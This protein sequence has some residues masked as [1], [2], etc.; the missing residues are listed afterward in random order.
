MT[1]TLLEATPEDVRAAINR[2]P[3]AVV[4]VT[5][6]SDEGHIALAVSTFV[7]ASF[8]PPLVLVCIPRSAAG[9]ATFQSAVAFGVS[10]LMPAQPEIAGSFVNRADGVPAEG[11]TIGAASGVPLLDGAVLQLDCA[12][13]DR[14]AA[15]DHIIM[16]GEVLAIGVYGGISRSSI[17]S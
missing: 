13:Y 10:S 8:D 14:H 4:V 12:T 16:V 15:G 5:V 7:S 1:G 3:A 6:S 11:W 2:I 9:F 17:S